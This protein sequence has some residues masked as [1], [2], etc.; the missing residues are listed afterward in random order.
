MST[1][2]IRSA[3]TTEPPRPFAAARSRQAAAR[4]GR[5]AAGR[6]NAA[7]ITQA[8]PSSFVTGFRRW[9]QLVPGR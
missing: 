8:R 9:S 1:A 2:G 7:R 4:T 3:R 5:A 6:M